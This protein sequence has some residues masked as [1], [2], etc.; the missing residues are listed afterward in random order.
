MLQRLS[1]SIVILLLN[2]C[3]SIPENSTIA[4]ESDKPLL[5]VTDESN[6]RVAEFSDPKM[7]ES[8]DGFVLPDI[9]LELPEPSKDISAEQ[10]D[11][12]SNALN[13]SLCRR[14]SPYLHA[15]EKRQPGDLVI[16]AALTGIRP[17]SRSVSSVSAVIDAVVPGPV[18]IPAGMGAI[19]VDA[20]A[21]TE[22]GTAAFIRWAKGANPV[23]TSAKISSIGDAYALVETFS[24]EFTELLLNDKGNGPVRAKLPAPEIQ[25]NENLC[26]KRFG[27]PDAAGK[28]ASFL[29]PLSPEFIDKG[30]PE[31]DAASEDG[32]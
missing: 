12:V 5:T 4:L 28:G 18:R 20:R 23:T 2:A 10:L 32:N 13:R 15:H 27:K 14:L 6:R 7:L 16:E 19:A 22:S 9:R 31:T 25:S 24:R 21:S 29:I 26:L 3:A 17:T 11:V 30:K 1:L 8:V